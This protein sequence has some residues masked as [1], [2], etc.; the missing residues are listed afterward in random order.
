MKKNSRELDTDDADDKVAQFIL[1]KYKSSFSTPAIVSGKKLGEF[2]FFENFSNFHA[3]KN[4]LRNKLKFLHHKKR[5]FIQMD[6]LDNI[7]IE[8]NVYVHCIAIFQFK[9]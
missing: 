8:L 9:R 1:S 2:A 3:S 6:F 7:W 5:I 4:A